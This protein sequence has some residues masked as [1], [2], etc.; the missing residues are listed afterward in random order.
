MCYIRICIYILIYIY[1]STYAYI[2]KFYLKK[3]HTFQRWQ[4]E[5]CEWILREERE[6]GHDI[7]IF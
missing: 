4:G 7:I 1:I 5:V 2:R 3:S 6:G